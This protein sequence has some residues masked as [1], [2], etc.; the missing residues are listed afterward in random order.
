[1]S[2]IKQRPI[3]LA[4]LLVMIAAGAYYFWPSAGKPPEVEFVV[5]VVTVKKGPIAKTVK[6]LANVSSRQEIAFLSHLKGVM[7]AIYVEEGM[8]VKKGT[9]LAELDNGELTQEFDH[10]KTKVKLALDKYKRFQQLKGTGA[11]SQA[12]LD[13][14]QDELLRAKIEYEHVLDRYNKTRFIAP[15]D[16]VC[17][18]FKFRPGQTV[19]DGD[20]V[21]SCY[22]ASGFI[23]KID[24]PQSLVSSVRP[25]QPVRYKDAEAKIA[26]VQTTL[27]PESHMGIARADVPATW[28]VSAGQMISVAV[29]VE[30]KDAVITLPRD[31]VFLKDGNSF[32]YTIVEGK[33]NLQSV[34]L[35]LQGKLLVEITEGLNEGDKVILKGQENIWP[36]RAVKELKEE[37]SQ[38]TE[39]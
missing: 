8:P 4:S 14:A 35:G 22:D 25:G 17:G 23:L 38:K 21:V 5:E 10:A 32:V 33:A 24:V 28:K 16:G 1:M 37:S 20:V 11:Q 29:D 31:A 13:K 18:V 6:M 7:K 34:E 36:T 9:V 3:F 26:S 15:F 12:G 39:E 27:D 19:S 2:Y 30:S